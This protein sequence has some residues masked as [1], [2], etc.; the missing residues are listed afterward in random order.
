MARYQE[1]YRLAVTELHAWVIKLSW[2][3]RIELFQVG[4]IGMLDVL[5]H[6]VVRQ[7]AGYNPM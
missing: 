2:R 3:L 6:R 7:V 4:G 5:N 1:A